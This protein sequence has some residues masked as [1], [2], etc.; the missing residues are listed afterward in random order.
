METYNDNNEFTETDSTDGKKPKKKRSKCCTCLIAFLVVFVILFS[1]AFGVGWYF[2][3]KFTQETFDLRLGEV[4]GAY[5]D[6]RTV[7]ERRMNLN[8]F[9]DNDLKQFENG[10][11]DQLYLNHTAP[12]PYEELF[13]E[14]FR[15]LLGPS[16]SQPKDEPDR[17]SARKPA[18]RDTLL[19]QTIQQHGIVTND[20]EE[21]SAGNPIVNAV[22]SLLNIQYVAVDRLE[23]YEGGEVEAFN[24]TDRQL[25]AFIDK[26]F[27]M[28]MERIETAAKEQGVFSIPAALKEMDIMQVRLAGTQQAPKLTATV[29]INFASLLNTYLSEVTSMRFNFLTWLLAPKHMYLSVEANLGETPSLKLQVNYL[30]EKK[31]ERL[32]KVL[33][34][35]LDFNIEEFLNEYAKNDLKPIT[36]TLHEYASFKDAPSGKV[37]MELWNTALHFSGIN[38]DREEDEKVT[39]ENIVYFLQGTLT[40]NVVTNEDAAFDNQYEKDGQIFYKGADFTGGDGYTLVDYEKEFL[41][42]LRAKYLI[43]DS[44][45]DIG[46]IIKLFGIGENLSEDDI[47]DKIR[48]QDISWLAFE[49][50]QENVF[51]ADNPLLRPNPDSTQRLIITDRMLGVIFQRFLQE[52]LGEAG[53]ETLGSL[54]PELSHIVLKKETHGGLTHNLIEVAFTIDVLAALPDNIGALLENLLPRRTMLTV[55]IDI[56]PSAPHGF[57]FIEGALRYNDLSDAET[58]RLLNNVRLL[59]GIDISP[60]TLLGEIEESFR[61]VISQMHDVMPGISLGESRKIDAGGY[62][63]TYIEGINLF[64]LL[65]AQLN[66]INASNPT[67]E[68]ETNQ[69]ELIDIILELWLESPEIMRDV[70]VRAANADESRFMNETKDK[71]YLIPTNE[72]RLETFDDFKAFIDAE[73]EDADRRFSFRNLNVHGEYKNPDDAPENFTLSKDRSMAYDVRDLEDLR[74][75]LYDRDFA[76]IMK[77]ELETRREEQTDDALDRVSVLLGFTEVVSVLFNPDMDAAGAVVEKE[78]NGKKFGTSPE[79]TVTMVIRVQQDKLIDDEGDK[80]YLDILPSEM[81]FSMQF[82]ISQANTFSFDDNPD[83]QYY[84][85]QVSINR[86]T[87]GGADYENLMKI[88]RMVNGG[89][90]PFNIDDLGKEVGHALYEQFTQLRSNLGEDNIRFTARD[91]QDEAHAQDKENGIEYGLLIGTV[92]HFL[93]ASITDEDGNKDDSLQAETLRG[94]LQGMYAYDEILS[95]QNPDYAAMHHNYREEVIV[96]NPF[97][98]DDLPT[99]VEYTNGVISD[100]QFGAILSSGQIYQGAPPPLSDVFGDPNPFALYEMLQFTVAETDA[101]HMLLSFTYKVPINF[102]DENS[103]D[104]YKGSQGRDPGY[105]GLMPEY[106]FLTF[107]LEW[108][109]NE[110]PRYSAGSFIINQLDPAQQEQFLAIT[111]YSISTMNMRLGE[112]ADKLNETAPFNT[113]TYFVDNSEGKIQFS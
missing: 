64:Q 89:E 37:H 39:S 26:I 22:A 27:K 87:Q 98:Q 36:D 47:M 63:E 32:N 80:R 7:S 78:E 33:S 91:A 95:A 46:D 103:E 48:L 73:E 15:P 28:G 113:V 14:L 69:H 100:R 92:Y 72:N 88:I 43:D 38:N 40:S 67:P 13:D 104:F 3:D 70:I 109:E 79:G 31:S 49:A 90:E 56:T 58:T 41:K 2:G 30:N 93:A 6:I 110:T 18:I 23:A 82:T 42:E 85:P 11:R 62:T 76:H 101:S 17:I 106:M 24:F 12:I 19:M 96:F 111:G 77:E 86:M 8:R 25:A 75:F 97:T 108:D 74:A 60:A 50:K 21:A 16:S 83:K 61:T 45:Q 94:A 54:N 84:L 9:N 51:L 65:A 53:D 112:F 52:G 34:R 55:T 99:L 35:I 105:W 29:R 102:K 57:E 66:E 10:V 44:I 107:T 71:Y 5:F 1:G 59:S 68:D 20:A 81:Y 4:V